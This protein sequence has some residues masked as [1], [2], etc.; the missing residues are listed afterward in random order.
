MMMIFTSIRFVLLQIVRKRLSREEGGGGSHCFGV[1]SCG[2]LSDGNH[3]VV[4]Q[5]HAN[6]L[7]CLLFH[8]DEQLL[9]LQHASLMYNRAH[10]RANVRL[11]CPASIKHVSH[12]GREC[13]N[14]RANTLAAH[15]VLMHIASP[16]SKGLE[17]SQHFVGNHGPAENIRG[18]VVGLLASDFNSHVSQSSDL[19]R[20]FERLV[21]VAA[22]KF[23]R[24]T[25][26]KQL[27]ASV[28]KS[29]VVWLKISKDYTT[30]MQIVQCRG[31]LGAHAKLF[32]V[33]RLVRRMVLQA[34][35]VFVWVTQSLP[36]VKETSS[37]AHGSF[38]LKLLLDEV[39]LGLPSTYSLVECFIKSIQH[40]EKRIVSTVRKRSNPIR[41]PPA[42]F[43]NIW[44]IE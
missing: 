10:G 2:G 3:E 7:D 44:M 27:N 13:G 42:N 35:S 26:I 43:K 18:N 15:Q 40:Q 17:E 12:V 24:K 14:F 23:S 36:N 25:K 20:H 11:L 22:R 6:I 19:T 33:Q 5:F 21:Q 38:L 34:W 4:G 8:A 37:T 29:D 28:Q 9:L 1:H 32:Q 30:F 16:S 31:N 39:F 41:G